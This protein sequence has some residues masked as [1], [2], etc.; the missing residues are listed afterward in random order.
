MRISD[1]SSDVCSSDLSPGRVRGRRR[2]H[3]DRPPRRNPRDLRARRCEGSALAR[4]QACRPLCHDRRARSAQGMKKADIEE[5]YR[6]LAAVNPEPTTEL[7]SVNDYT[8]L[9]AVVLSAQATDV[10][11]N[12][13]TRRLF[14]Q[15][16]T[17]QAMLD[18]GEEGLKQHIKTIDLFHSTAKNVIALSRILAD[19]YSA[20]MPPAP[21]AL[22]S[23]PGPRIT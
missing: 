12:K 8:L 17:P 4:R 14:E 22:T 20:H 9:V 23:R 18:L 21:E 15:V 1:W 2:A 7:Q 16:Q 13:A 10:G 11:V 3:R 5:F 19:Q 6:R